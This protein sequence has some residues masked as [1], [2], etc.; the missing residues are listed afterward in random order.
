MAMKENI[1]DPI[2]LG[3]A[4]L[5]DPT[6]RAVLQRLAAGEASVAELMQPFELSQPTISKHLKVLEDAGLIE[7]GRH[8]QRRPRRLNREGVET[9]SKWLEDFRQQW[10]RRFDN[11]ETY[12]TGVSQNGQAPKPSDREP[13]DQDADGR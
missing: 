1:P 6:R 3:F 13:T 7:I 10:D 2:S 9:L 8:A 11:L 12:L 4:A 5:A